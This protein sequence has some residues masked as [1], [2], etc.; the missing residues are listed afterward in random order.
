VDGRADIYSLACVAYFMLTG[1]PVFSA[2]TAVA[3]ALAHVKDVPIPPSVRS[4]LAIPPALDAVILE[5]LAKDPAQRPQSA[6]VLGERLA[7]TVAKDA[8]TADAAHT[9]WE[10]HRVAL[11][12]GVPATAEQAEGEQQAPAV[13]ERPRCWPRLDRTPLTRE[14]LQSR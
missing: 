10:L 5:C 9:W 2:D 1:Q 11:A 4:E 12:G 3:T 7:A 14:S 13:A 8:W 6:A